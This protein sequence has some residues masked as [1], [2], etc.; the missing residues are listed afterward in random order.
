MT[1]IFGFANQSNSPT[2]SRR[3][4]EER[5]RNVKRRLDFGGSTLSPEEEKARSDQY[6]RRMH[7][8]IMLESRQKW[9]FDFEAD[10]PHLPASSS[11]D[12]YPLNESNVP[13]CYRSTEKSSENRVPS[14]ADS[15]SRLQLVFQTPNKRKLTEDSSSPSPVVPESPRKWSRVD[16]KS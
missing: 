8:Q 4:A 9:G 1:K 10:H 5:S 3:L 6:L 16:R 7:E 14:A 2:S 15:S 12:W 13:N 11:W